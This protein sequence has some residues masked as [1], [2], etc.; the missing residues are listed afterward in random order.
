[1]PIFGLYDW[2]FHGLIG[3]PLPSGLLMKN[4]RRNVSPRVVFFAY[5]D[6]IRTDIDRGEFLARIC[7][8]IEFPGSY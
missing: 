1:L 4:V 2:E 8:D 3:R 5:L 7:R 6:Q